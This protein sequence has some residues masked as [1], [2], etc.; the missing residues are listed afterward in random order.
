[1]RFRAFVAA[2][3]E[4]EER[5]KDILTGLR[6]SGADLKVV[7]PELMHVTVK[8]LGD[9]EEDMVDGIASRIDNAVRDVQP[10][11]VK[12]VGMGAFP[13]LSNIR[14][15][16]VGMEDSGILARTAKRLD[17]SLVE[18]GF[19]PDRKGFKPHLTV[20]RARST[21]GMGAVQAILKEKAT[22]DFGTYKVGSIRLKKSVLGPQGPAYSDVRTIP[23][24]E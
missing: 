10:F 4:P 3:I 13:S 15:V 8:F 22:S 7:R 9:T 24:G 20:A 18:L 5:L 21:S 16:W 19:E 12:L 14:V 17:D 2:D 23:L 11:D 6:R 1:M